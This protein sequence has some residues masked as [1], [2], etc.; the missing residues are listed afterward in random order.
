MNEVFL[1]LYQVMDM[2]IVFNMQ[3]NYTSWLHRDN[4]LSFSG[5]KGY[6]KIFCKTAIVSSI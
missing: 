5:T 6:I 1:L 2:L 4:Y 3:F